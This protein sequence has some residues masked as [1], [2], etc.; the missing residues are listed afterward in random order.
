M[1]E[2]T[3]VQTESAPVSVPVSES[4]AGLDVKPSSIGLG[5][6]MKS[7]ENTDR[8]PPYQSFILRADGHT[9][10]K[11]TS[12][13]PK[14]FDAGFCLA[15][16][17]TAQST[18]SEFH[19]KTVYVCS[20]EISAIFSPVCTKAEYDELVSTGEKQLPSHIFS[21]RHNKIESLFASYCSVM[22]NKFML[23]EMQKK[24][25]TYSDKVILRIEACKATFDARMIPIPMGSEIETVN[26]IIWRSSYDCYRNTTST[27]GRHILG[28]KACD[29][30]NSTQMIQMM[31]EKG[32]D[33]VEH[34]PLWYKYGILCKK[35]LKE[36]TDEDGKTYT[37]AKVHSFC[38]NLIN[39]D[40]EKVLEL[41]FAKYY[42]QLIDVTEVD[43]VD[44]V[45]TEVI[46]TPASDP[47]LTA[48]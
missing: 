17:K 3:T 31:A 24:R 38:S 48:E 7:Y 35:Q 19:P 5:D 18:L 45:L 15:M 1:A 6:R 46:Q 26:N 43:V 16:L 10:S 21:G 47:S 8:V 4:D 37:R 27:F 33:Y 40:K 12:G 28:T 2:N 14:P 9:F 34:V 44:G 41:F 25:S 20:D 30:K 23:E 22:F 11:Y 42:E 29:H 39:L 13:F 32:F 36:F